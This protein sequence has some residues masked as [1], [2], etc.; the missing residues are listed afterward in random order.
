M[1]NVKYAMVG[2]PGH[3]DPVAGIG[4]SEGMPPHWALTFAVTDAKAAVEVATAH[5]GEVVAPVATTEFGQLAVLRG[6]DG[7]M[8]AV[9]GSATES[10]TASKTERSLKDS[11]SVSHIFSPEVGLG[12]KL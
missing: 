2:V 6:P 7:E 3:D 9:M 8:F 12:S 11:S 5:G 1:E 4:L 10:A